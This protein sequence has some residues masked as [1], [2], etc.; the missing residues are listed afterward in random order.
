MASSSS[1]LPGRSKRSTIASRFGVVATWWRVQ[2]GD[3][4]K[5]A[6]ISILVGVVLFLGACWWDARLQARQDALASAIADRQD[7][8]ARDLANQA[9]VLENTRF[10]RSIATSGGQR[11]KPFA[12]INLGGAEL[13]G[14]FLGC[15]NSRGGGCADFSKADLQEANL[16]SA[17]LRGAG[18]SEADLRKANLTG[19]DFSAALFID[20]NLDGVATLRPVRFRDAKFFHATLVQAQLDGAD[21]IHA[22]ISDDV[23]ADQAVL[24][25][26]DFRKSYLGQARFQR[27]D[28][29]DANFRGALMTD[30]DLTSADL[31]DMNFTG[32]KMI[33]V[34][35][36]SADL[37]G[38][39]FTGTHLRRTVF[40]GVCFDHT[41]KWDSISPPTSSSC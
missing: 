1:I 14:L 25:H 5:D 7:R 32:A 20:A 18:F 36:T 28:L 6:L 30:I 35:L 34:D 22:Q 39:D 26:G 2:R 41:T 4:A 9:E 38:A 13:G 23:K 16:T 17:L 24:T 37:R 8:L 31:R 29:R 11:P 10:V 33:N 3:L 40:T 12:S 19:S 21:F 27:A 15:N